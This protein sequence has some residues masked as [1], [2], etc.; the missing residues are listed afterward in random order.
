M[1]ATNLRRNRPRVIDLYSGVGGFSLGAARAGFEIIAAVDL[2]KR[3]IESHA[4]NFPSSRHSRRNIQ[5]LSGHDL[6]QL[7]RVGN[8]RLEGIIGGPPCQGFS[9]MGRMRRNDSRN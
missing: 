3:A 8:S 4:V 9:T 2:D 1:S 6:M 7:A 5:G